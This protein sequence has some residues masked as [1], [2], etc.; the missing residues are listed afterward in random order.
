MATE[1]EVFDLMAHSLRAAA[2]ICTR[3]AWDKKRGF[4]Y[5]GGYDR[6]EDKRYEGLTEHLKDAEGCCRQA[7]IFHQ[8]YHWSLMSIK[9]GTA[10][11][12]A[13]RWMRSSPTQETR[14]AAHRLFLRLADELRKIEYQAER[15]KTAATGRIGMILP[16][17]LPEPHQRESRPVSIILP[18]SSERVH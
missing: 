13:G 12:M 3:I 16:E 4:L 7:F 6:R 18:S 2:D 5:M 11:K 17:P 10:H 8:D 15:L 1:I 14:D 9:L